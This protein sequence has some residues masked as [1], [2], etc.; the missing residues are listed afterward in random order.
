ME[1]G[2][3]S[4]NLPVLLAKTVQL[5]ALPAHLPVPISTSAAT[6]AYQYVP[7]QHILINS[8]NAAVVS[9]L[10]PI[11]SQPPTVLPVKM[12]LIFMLLWVSAYLSASVTLL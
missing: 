1:V 7:I 3:N 11:A 6:N 8:V 12:V 5:F 4:V 10:A 9:L 2:A